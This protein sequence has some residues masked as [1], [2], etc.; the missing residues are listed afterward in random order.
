MG[1][2]RVIKVHTHAYAQFHSND[3][4]GQPLSLGLLMPYTSPHSGPSPHCLS[5]RLWGPHDWYVVA[6]QIYV[7][8]HVVNTV[9]THVVANL[10]KNV[11][12]LQFRAKNNRK[13]VKMFWVT[14]SSLNGKMTWKAKLTTCRKTELNWCWTANGNICA[15]CTVNRCIHIFAITC[16]KIAAFLS[17]QHNCYTWTLDCISQCKI[18]FQEQNL[19]GACT[20]EIDPTVLS[21]NEA[22]FHLSR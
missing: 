15:T 8:T 3:P 11:M 17:V 5:E 10:D 7:M 4:T 20:G 2:I 16:N 22:W 21:S 13:Y 14:S 6:T 12:L 1:K 9:A 19:Q 18:E